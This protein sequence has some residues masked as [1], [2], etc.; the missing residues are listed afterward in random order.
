MVFIYDGIH[1][2]KFHAKNFKEKKEETIKVPQ[3]S[4]LS[5]QI[6]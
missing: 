2:T 1:V 3:H 5:I 4:Y 6:Y